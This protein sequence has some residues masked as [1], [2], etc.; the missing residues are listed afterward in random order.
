[1]K[2]LITRGVGRV[3]ETTSNGKV[4]RI[5]KQALTTPR[6]EREGWAPMLLEKRKP[7][8]GNQGCPTRSC[9]LKAVPLKVWSLDQQDQQQLE[10]Y[11]KFKFS[12]LT[13]TY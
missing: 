2:R 7:L 5:G 1:M 8:L 4:L 3:K 6:P 9:G 10:T 11:E 12:G 13:P